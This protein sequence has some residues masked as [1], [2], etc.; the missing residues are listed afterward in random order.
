MKNPILSRRLLAWLPPAL[1]L[2]GAANHFY[3]VNHHQMSPWLGAG[4][5]MFATTDVGSARL[6][7]VSA[8]TEDGSR[9]PVT[10]NESLS[11]LAKQVRGL[12]DRAQ[13]GALADGILNDLGYGRSGAGAGDLTTLSIDVWRT[14]YDPGTLRPHQTRVSVERF[15]IND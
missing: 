6:L 12:P 8:E 15:A 2:A 14:R 13:S 3:L 10:L 1:L 7:V 9:Y 11:E 4:F 5:G